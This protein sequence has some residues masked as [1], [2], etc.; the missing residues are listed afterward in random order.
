RSARH[1]R[2]DAR[3]GSGQAESRVIPHAASGRPAIT[4][5]VVLIHDV[6]TSDD[7]VASKTSNNT[8]YAHTAMMSRVRT[9]PM[10]NVTANRPPMSN[11]MASLSD[12]IHPAS[13]TEN[14]SAAPPV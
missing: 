2:L 11:P 6:V 5:R 14:W 12:W 1:G 3:S 10:T 13:G 8:R 9:A 7:N 4:A